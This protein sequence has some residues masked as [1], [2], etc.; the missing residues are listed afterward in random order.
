MRADASG[1]WPGLNVFVRDGPARYIFGCE[2]VVLHPKRKLQSKA[3]ENRTGTKGCK[4]QIGCGSKLQGTAA[5]R[6]TCPALPWVAASPDGMAITSSSSCSCIC[7][8]SSFPEASRRAPSATSFAPAP[9]P[10]PSTS[11]LSPAAPFLAV[12]SCPCGALASAAS[13]RVG[14]A[15]GIS[16]SSQSTASLAV[17]APASPC[18]GLPPEP[19][20]AVGAGRQCV[21]M[22][23]NTSSVTATLFVPF[24]HAAPNAS[25]SHTSFL[26]TRKGRV[27]GNPQS[28]IMCSPAP[29]PHIQ[30]AAPL[31]RCRYSGGPT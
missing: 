26:Y 1:P 21:D 7:T 15:L 11:I 22:K 5:V 25:S 13:A 20:F 10:S 27:R 19:G 3:P 14:A 4:H 17:P 9:A 29:L 30:H 8:E 2:H 16:T 24:L 6:R 12:F 31:S 18:P 28:T 23:R